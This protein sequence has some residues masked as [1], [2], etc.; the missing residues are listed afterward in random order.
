MHNFPYTIPMETALQIIAGI[1][2]AVIGWVIRLLMGK[3]SG[4]EEKLV[5]NSTHHYSKEESLNVRVSV[6][7]ERSR[8]PLK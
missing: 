2:L 8:H 4:I 7:E 6:L 1:I 3:I 5:K